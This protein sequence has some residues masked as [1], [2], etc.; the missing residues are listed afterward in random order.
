[1]YGVEAQSSGGGGL[2][3]QLPG[4]NAYMAGALG[5]RGPAASIIAGPGY[6][7]G[8]LPYAAAI[9]R[10]VALPPSTGAG[11]TQVQR[12]DRPAMMGGSWRELLDPHNS[13]AL[14]ILIGLLVLYGWL[15]ASVRV[16]AGRR[17][18]AAA[19]L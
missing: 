13:P 17:A 11:A 5:I 6:S 18:S 15:H 19:V 2:M 4:G 3:A 12:P 14:W 7:G 9:N 1:M 10:Q 16:S 8:R